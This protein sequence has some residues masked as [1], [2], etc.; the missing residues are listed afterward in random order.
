MFSVGVSSDQRWGCDCGLWWLKTRKAWRWLER[1]G[2][3][4][5]GV[6]HLRRVWLQLS[7]P[8]GG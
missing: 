2:E 5:C 4:M 8:M 3:R 1:D 6:G 7:M